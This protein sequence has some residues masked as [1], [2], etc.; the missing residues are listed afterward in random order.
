MFDQELE[1]LKEKLS[2]ADENLRQEA[3]YMLGK[4][5]MIEAA[6]L[7][8]R[9]TVDPSPTVRKIAKR[10]IERLQLVGIS[11]DEK[12]I[13][14]APPVILTRQIQI[15]PPAS[16][17][18]SP[19]QKP[20]QNQPSN[21]TIKLSPPETPKAP[22]NQLVSKK[23]PILKVSPSSVINP[24]AHTSPLSPTPTLSPAS[25]NIPSTPQKIT[26]SFHL[27]AAS[28]TASPLTESPNAQTSQPPRALPAVKG[29]NKSTA[30]AK[31]SEKH[32]PTPSPIA[33]TPAVTQPSTK[34]KAPNS[35]H[36]SAKTE[37]THPSPEE[38]DK[39]INQIIPATEASGSINISAPKT[40]SKPQKTFVSQPEKHPE[41]KEK[42]LKPGHQEFV[43]WISEK[44]R[45]DKI[46][47]FSEIE[48]HSRDLSWSGTIKSFLDSEND[49]FV[50]SKAIKSLGKH[51]GPGIGKIIDQFLDNSDER[52]IS[53]S[54]EALSIAGGSEE[55]SRIVAY[56]DHSDARI[57]STAAQSLWKTKPEDSMRVIKLM[58]KSTKVWE[59]DAA[60]FALESCPLEEGKTLYAKLESS[61]LSEKEAVTDN[62][63]QKIELSLFWKIMSH[64]VYYGAD[65]P[66]PLWWAVSSVVFF[67]FFFFCVAMPFFDWLIPPPPDPLL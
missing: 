45:Q 49:P 32:I 34:G 14:K 52:V 10:S 9:A 22:E 31:G 61:A 17:K 66:I 43:S 4:I 62:K 53:N 60:K 58:A 36:L 41:W 13:P 19:P 44:S 64:P 63:S 15:Q 11:P 26:P 2:D 51:H 39:T 48:N 28:A 30:H 47:I 29:S 25:S 12:S 24:A 40:I 7:L 3:C 27:P 35:S 50:I 6:N 21:Q 37:K 33:S 8:A 18:S 67:F 57:R 23:I 16:S 54:L 46:E 55:I 20:H 1:E 56:L 59:R 65:D 38:P 42:L 5:E